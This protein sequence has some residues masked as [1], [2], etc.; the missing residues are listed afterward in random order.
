MPWHPKSR[1]S[2]AENARV[3]AHFCCNAN[4]SHKL[5]I[6]FIG[7]AAKPRCFGAA[8]IHLSVFSWL[9]K[10]YSMAWM[11]TGIMVEW[12]HWFS[13]I[14]GTRKALS[15]M[16]NNDAPTAAVYFIRECRPLH[17]IAIAWPPPSSTSNYQPLN[18]VII[19]TFEAGYR[20]KFF[21]LY[22]QLIRGS[23]ASSQDNERA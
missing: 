2:K 19:R 15:I 12:L 6:W 8:D 5:P 7:E 1:W 14:I 20:R 16:D 9:W 18:Q 4:G 10:H 21:S 22:S 3:T 17:N 23:Q 11:I 13:S